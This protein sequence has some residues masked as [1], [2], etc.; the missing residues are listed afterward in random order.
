MLLLLLLSGKESEEI[1]LFLKASD[2]YQGPLYRIPWVVLELQ[3]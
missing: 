3:Y 2:N 1:Y